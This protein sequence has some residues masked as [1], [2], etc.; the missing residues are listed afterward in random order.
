MNKISKKSIAPTLKRMEIN[1]KEVF[2]PSQYTSLNAA[3]V[4]LQTETGK[5]FKRNKVMQGNEIVVFVT[6]TA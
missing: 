3:I 4:N 2:S 6:R 5:K 1:D